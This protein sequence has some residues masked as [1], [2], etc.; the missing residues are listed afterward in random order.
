MT[1]FQD[2][3]LKNDANLIPLYFSPYLME[4]V[5][6]RHFVNMEYEKGILY[7]TKGQLVEVHIF[8]K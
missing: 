6:I 3:F 2:F 8:R 4:I 1:I 5:I 7:K